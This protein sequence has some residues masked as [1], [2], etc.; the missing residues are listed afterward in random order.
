MSYGREIAE[1]YNG[2][3]SPVTNNESLY[4]SKFQEPS[5]VQKE[6]LK[7]ANQ[8]G[9]ISMAFSDWLFTK[10]V[11]LSSTKK[12]VNFFDQIHNIP[13]TL[14]ISQANTSFQGYQTFQMMGGAE[15]QSKVM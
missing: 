14:P 5:Q 12:I 9:K 1:S 11:G 3:F 4:L 7:Q 8:C 15:N 13:N 6:C 2:L 10:S